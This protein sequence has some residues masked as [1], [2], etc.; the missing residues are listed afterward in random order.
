MLKHHARYK[1]AF[2]LA[3]DLAQTYRYLQAGAHKNWC[4]CYVLS[5]FAPLQ[6][7]NPLRLIAIMFNSDF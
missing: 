5:P 6:G 2:Y 4:R 3:V 1:I 7:K